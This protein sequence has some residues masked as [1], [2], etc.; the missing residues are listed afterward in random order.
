MLEA[1]GA[2]NLAVSARIRSAYKQVCEYLH[3]LTGK[4]F[5][6]KVKNTAYTVYTRNGCEEL[7]DIWI[8]TW[9][10]KCEVYLDRTEMSM[11]PQ[12]CLL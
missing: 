10:M 2:C 6:L 4:R 7:W 12:A 5:S 8:Y 3:I 9:L 11:I 1:D